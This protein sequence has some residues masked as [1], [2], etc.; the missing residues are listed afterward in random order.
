MKNIVVFLLLGVSALSALGQEA[1]TS[2]TQRA[3]MK[4]LQWLVGNWTGTGWIQMGPQGR[5]EFT[6]TEVVQAKLDGLVL[7]IEGVG[8]SPTDGALVHSALAFVSYDEPTQKFRWRAFTVEGRQTDV[9]AKV[10]TDTLEWGFEISPGRRVRYTVKRNQ[11][12]HWFEV[13]EMTQDGQTWR[14]F[15]EMTLQRNR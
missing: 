8:K 1:A 14:K 13:G 4:K 10:D 9:E 2:E 12:N 5:K 3:Q 6:Q 7:I 15:F 11:N